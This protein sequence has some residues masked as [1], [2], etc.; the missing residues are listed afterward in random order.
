MAT[1][2]TPRVE[3]RRTRRRYR[4]AGELCPKS[5]VFLVSVAP[6][7]GYKADF[8]GLLPPLLAVQLDA[9]HA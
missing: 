8:K 7:N 5:V 6:R 4:Q 3:P 9:D 2:T 1:E